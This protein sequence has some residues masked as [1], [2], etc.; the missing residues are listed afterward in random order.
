MD[1][2]FK[3]KYKYVYI[4]YACA[5]GDG[6]YL[7]AYADTL[8]YAARIEADRIKEH[9]NVFKV[10]SYYDKGEFFLVKISFSNRGNNMK[11]SISSKKFTPYLPKNADFTYCKIK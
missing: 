6:K 9:F 7:N 8:D 10:K 11:W 5:L 2:I 4:L 1:I 3:K